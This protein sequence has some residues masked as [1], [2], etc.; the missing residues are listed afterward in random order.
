MYKTLEEINRR[1]APFS[2]Y[3]AEE[4]W[5]DE[6]TSKKMLEFHLNGAVDISSRRTEFIDRSAL[7]ISSRFELAPGKSVADFGCGP[8]L[9]TIRLAG[10]GADVT[11]IDFSERSI[12]FAR[13][14]SS[15][16]G[17][18]VE[19]VHG[20]YLKFESEKRFDL[21]TMIMCDFCA[22]SPDQREIMLDKFRTHLRPEGHLLL[23]VYSLNAFNARAEES[24][25]SPNLL[26]GFWSAESYFGFL[27]TFKYDN[28]KVTLDKYTIIEKARTRVIYNWLQHF[29]SES[30]KR[31]LETSGFVLDDLLGD[32]A[33]TPFDPSLN[34]FA[35]IARK[36]G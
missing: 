19:Y 12:Q 30:L 32:V 18:P 3:T 27:N 24:T 20:D 9:Y 36:P 35:V 31:E 11:G 23:D 26:D 1:P 13:E 10:T 33:G 16:Q 6:H 14:K 17:V 34:E 21:I 15:I 2:E 7:W 29:D 4:L 25:Y 8:G 22:L 5:A 28:E